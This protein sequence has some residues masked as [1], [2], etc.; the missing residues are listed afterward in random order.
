MSLVLRDGQLVF[1]ADS[2]DFDAV[3]SDSGSSAHA[4][5]A[6]AISADFGAA[7]VLQSTASSHA[8]AC[9]ECAA[10]LDELV[11]QLAT[12]DGFELEVAAEVATTAEVAEPC[13]P[14]M[15]PHVL[16]VAGGVHLALMAAL[17]NASDLPD[18]F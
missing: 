9:A 17:V 8:G 6:S 5:A 16:H 7:S 13:A 1:V 15:P 10:V 4:P 2:A 11:N 14:P 3:L 12:G 18:R